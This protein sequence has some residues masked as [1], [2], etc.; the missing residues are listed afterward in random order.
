MVIEGNRGLFR[1][2]NL[3]PGLQQGVKTALCSGDT[4]EKSDDAA[5]GHNPDA[6]TEPGL[7]P[8]SQIQEETEGKQNGQTELG[9]PQDHG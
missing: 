1:R 7:Q 6:Q 2:R 4:G 5:D 9:Y 8:K 3:I